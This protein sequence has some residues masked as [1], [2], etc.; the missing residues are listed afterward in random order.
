MSRYTCST[1]MPGLEKPPAPNTSCSRCHERARASSYDLVEVAPLR[2]NPVAVAEQP[3][4]A[5][6][7]AVMREPHERP[8]QDRAPAPIFRV[9]ESRLCS[10]ALYA[11]MKRLHEIEHR[12]PQPR[13]DGRALLVIGRVLPRQVAD[14][15]L[16]PRIELQQRLELR[17][18]DV[19]PAA[20]KVRQQLERLRAALRA[21]RRI[22]Q[23]RDETA[24]LRGIAQRI[25]QVPQPFE[26]GI[27]HRGIGKGREHPNRFRRRRPSF[28]RRGSSRCAATRADRCRCRAPRCRGTFAA[29]CRRS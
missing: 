25:L 18:G 21:R 24:H 29:G 15:R 28:A 16:E 3:E 4:L 11:A 8:R 9:R 17:R 2:G 22:G 1:Q 14:D 7:P 27:D 19:A 10:A 13:L 26:D 20:G 23:P 5:V 6:E 12:V